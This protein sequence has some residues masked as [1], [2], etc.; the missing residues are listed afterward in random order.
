MSATWGKRNPAIREILRQY[1]RIWAM[2]H[3][4][5]VLG[6]DTETG[7]PEAGATARGMA[8]GQLQIMLQKAF[9]ELRDPV[10]KAEKSKE[11]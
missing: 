8:S 3:S 1:Q 7:M 11:K 2:G 9:L 10:K 6:W 4:L 5:A